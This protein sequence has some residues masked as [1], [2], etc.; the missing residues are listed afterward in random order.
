MRVG[1]HGYLEVFVTNVTTLLIF[2]T[3]SIQH[4]TRYRQSMTS[5]N[6]GAFN[7]SEHTNVIASNVLSVGGDIVA[8]W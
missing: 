6:A 4:H 3:T 5:A 8:V 2:I 7:A 1:S